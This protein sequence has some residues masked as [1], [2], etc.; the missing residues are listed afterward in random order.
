MAKCYFPDYNCPAV[1][2][3]LDLVLPILSRT[4]FRLYEL[5]LKPINYMKCRLSPVKF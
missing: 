5:A 4:T 1:N 3:L 2:H